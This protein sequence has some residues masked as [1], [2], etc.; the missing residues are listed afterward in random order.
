MRAA[1][2]FFAVFF[3]ANPLAAR[4][5]IASRVNIGINLAPLYSGLPELQL[6]CFLNRYIGVTA[7]GGYL[8]KARRGGIKVDGSDVLTDAHGAYF[9]VGLKGRFV[10]S[11]RN[12]PVPWAQVLYIY[13]QYNDEGYYE[14]DLGFPNDYRHYKGA[15]NGFAFSIGGDF[16]IWRRLDF[17]A[18]F[19]ATIYC[20][21]N[22]NEYIGLKGNTFQPG[23]GPEPGT[24]IV[25]FN[26]RIGKLP[27]S[28]V[29]KTATAH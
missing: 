17:R 7:S 21:R 2:L 4:D 13:S 5:P 6:E 26:Y 24:L 28:S 9:K 14:G 22:G 15:A 1:F 12:V 20:S 19:Q 18:G 10:Y 8:N 27:V 25:G 23:M 16:P 29:P 3:F 11:R